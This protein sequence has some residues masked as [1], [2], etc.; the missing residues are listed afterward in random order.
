MTFYK[1]KRKWSCKCH[2]FGQGCLTPPPQKKNI[3]TEK[4]KVIVANMCYSFILDIDLKLTVG[5]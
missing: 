4:V 2:D 1:K 3:A 5:E